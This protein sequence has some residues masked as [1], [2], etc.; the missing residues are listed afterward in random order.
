MQK[1][2]QHPHGLTEN[3]LQYGM[4]YVQHYLQKRNIFGELREEAEAAGY[5]GLV[6][7]WNTWNPE[8]GKWA[9]WMIGKIQWAVVEELRKGRRSRH[10]LSFRKNFVVVP[11]DEPGNPQLGGDTWAEVFPCNRPQ[12]EQL[13]IERLCHSEIRAAIQNLPPR[14]RHLIEQ[15]YY[16]QRRSEE[17]LDDP[18]MGP[19]RLSS[20]RFY[21]LHRQAIQRLKNALN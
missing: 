6:Q 11:L 15:F 21:Q 19:K 14:E 20:G 18:E 13:A 16:Q 3:D 7:A 1:T 2:R 17:I 10:Y 5:A 8:K 12:T 9:T 4:R